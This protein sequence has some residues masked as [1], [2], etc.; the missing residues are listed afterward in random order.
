MA[1]VVKNQPSNAGD[2]GDW[3]SI[4]ESGRSPRGGHGN[5]PQ[6][7][8]LEN[9]MDRGAWRATVIRLTKSKAWLSDISSVQSLSHVQLCDPMDCRTLG[10]PVYH[11]LLELGQTHVHQVSDAIQ[12]SH[13]LSFP[14]PAF[15]LSQHQGLFQWVTSLHQMLKYWS[16]RF[17][18][19]PSNEYSGLIS[20]RID[21]FDRLAVQG[22]L[23]SLLQHHSSKALILQQSAFFI[24]QLSHLYMTTGKTIVLTV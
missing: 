3:S 1:L 19:S 22:T 10:F 13:P 12:P 15:N 16:F 11:Q 17:S 9:P 6:Y 8:C 5:L 23:N 7:S 18:F 24:V 20:F 4:P 2:I 14:S 21:W